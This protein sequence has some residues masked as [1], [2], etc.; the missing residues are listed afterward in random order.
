MTDLSMRCAGNGHEKIEVHSLM[1]GCGTINNGIGIS[2]GATG[3][4]VLDFK[5]MEQVVDAGRAMRQRWQEEKGME[6]PQG[7]TKT[8]T[9]C[10]HVTGPAGSCIVT[11]ADEGCAVLIANDVGRKAGYNSAKEIPFLHSDTEGCR[12]LIKTEAMVEV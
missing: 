5:D 11:A 1:A 10:F 9:K 7:S 4:F 12:V 2:F 6:F 8:T 3:G